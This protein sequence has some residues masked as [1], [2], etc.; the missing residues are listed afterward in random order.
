MKHLTT[1]DYLVRVQTLGFDIE[2]T[3]DKKSIFVS[4]DKHV[5]LSVRVDKPYRI[6]S[7]WNGLS[8][9]LG[10]QSIVRE[11]LVE[12]LLNITTQYAQ[13]P[14]IE[15]GFIHDASA[16]TKFTIEELRKYQMRTL[17]SLEAEGEE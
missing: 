5:I 16:P 11:M 3:L 2:F 8:R 6:D 12:T 1:L 13:T 10:D 9:Y 14:T 7:N 4:K 15:R 17:A